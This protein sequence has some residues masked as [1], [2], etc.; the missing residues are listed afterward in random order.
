MSVAAPGN[1][2]SSLTGIVVFPLIFYG[3]ENP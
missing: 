3:T 1:S 2:L